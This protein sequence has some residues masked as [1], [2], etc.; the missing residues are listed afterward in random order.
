MELQQVRYL[1][2]ALDRSCSNNDF[3]FEASQWKI[4]FPKQPTFATAL[5]DED[6]IFACML[7]S[8]LLATGRDLN[9]FH[10]EDMSLLKERLVWF[11]TSAEVSSN[12]KELLS[13]YYLKYC[14]LNFLFSPPLNTRILR[15]Y[16]GMQRCNEWTPAYGLSAGKLFGRRISE[17]FLKLLQFCLL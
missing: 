15:R 4:C 3:H 11:H 9:T 14:V 12:S 13:V 6:T 1:L 10:G 17:T 5:S 2:Q 8:Y 7:F 16:F